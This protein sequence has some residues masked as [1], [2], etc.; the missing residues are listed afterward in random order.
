MA[1][2]GAGGWGGHLGALHET[3]MKT[4]IVL[5]V[6]L[7]LGLPVLAAAH[8]EAK[9]PISAVDAPRHDQPVADPRPAYDEAIRQP[10]PPP[11]SRRWTARSSPMAR[12]DTAI[13]RSSSGTTV[14]RRRV[15]RAAAPPGAPSASDRRRPTER[16]R[17][18]IKNVGV[19]GCGLMGSGIV[20]VSAQ[21]GFPFSSSRPTT[22]W[23]SAAS[24]GCA[25]RW[26]AWPAAASSR[27][28]PRTHPRPHR[29]HAAIRRS[30]GLRPR[31]RGHD[32]ESGAQERDVRQARPHLPAARAAGHQH[33]VVQ[34]HR[35]GGGHQAPRR[36]CW[37]F[38]SSTRCR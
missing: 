7:L 1:L 12:C 24:V 17:M 38:T 14:P 8:D 11:A 22:S 25:R 35:D 34:R 6:T 31:R 3:S 23:S 29:R 16:P 33:L 20:Q 26:K 9:T 4:M 15:L 2:P 18:A 19:I 30:Q 5:S 10:G 28:R 36:R 13:R 21:A 37:G 27:P 32:R